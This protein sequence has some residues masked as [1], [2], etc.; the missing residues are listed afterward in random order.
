MNILICRLFVENDTSGNSLMNAFKTLGHNTFTCG[1]KLGNFSGE[2]LSE[3]DIQVYDKPHPERYSYDEIVNKINEKKLKIDLIVQ[4]DSHFYFYGNPPEEIIT[5]YY[6]VDIHRG[7]LV[8]RNLAIEGNFNLLFLA[9]KYFE[10]HFLRKNLNPIWLPRAFDDTY[11]KEYP[12]IK[13]ECDI[14]FCGETGISKSI[15]NFPYFDEEIGKHYHEGP[16]KDAPKEWCYKGWGNRSMEYAERAELLIRLSKDYNVRIYEYS[17]G[18]QYAKTIC[19]GKIGFNR[20]LYRDS[21]LRNFEIMACNRLL[22]TDDLPYQEELFQDKVHCRTYRNYYQP[23]FPN[24]DLDYEEVR[25]LVD[26]Y[27]EHERER[28]ELA[29]VGREHVFKNHTFRNRAEKI[30]EHVNQYNVRRTR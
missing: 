23:Q 30:L 4:L 10:R 7:G 14:S 6:L 12:E 25:S 19:R 8:F 9:H 22:I 16:F 27:L 17:F 11:V 28:K 13:Q 29:I 2:L 15:L 18:E 3:C 5:A 21:A 1:P 20:S 26:Y 24:F